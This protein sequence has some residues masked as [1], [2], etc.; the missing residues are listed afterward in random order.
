MS[1]TRRLFLKAILAI[2]SSLAIFPFLYGCVKKEPKETSKDPFVLDPKLKWG[3]APCRYC[4]TGCGVMVGVENGKIAAVVGDKLNSVNKGLL[5]AKGY[6]LPAM[7]YGKDRLTTPLIRKNGTLMPASWD[8]ALDLI[9]TRFKD[10]LD[11]SGP[12][13]VAMYGSGQWTI[14]DGYIATKF[15]RAAI[16]SNNLE[17][18]ARLCMASAVTGFYTTFG[19]DE[20]MGCYDDFEKADAFILWGNNMAEMHPVLFSRILE[21][22]RKSPWVQIIDIATRKTETTKWADIYVE[23]KP[24]T[25][26]ALANC[27]ARYIIK[28]GSYDRKFIDD[29]VLFKKG[30]TDIGYGLEDKFSFKDEPQSITMEELENSL[31]KYTFEYTSKITGVKAG[32]LKQ[33]AKIYADKFTKLVSLWCMGVNQHTRGTWMNNLIYNLHLLTGKI[34]IPG[35]NP[36]SL[37]GQPSACGTVREVGTLAHKLPANLV[38]MKPAHREKAAK[39]WNILPEKIPAKPGYNTMEMFRAMDRGDIKLMWIQCTNPYVTLPNLKRYTDSAKRD[40]SFI[41]VSDIYPTPTT[42]IAD[43]VLPSAAWVERE[44]MFGNSER[45]TQQWFKMVDPP[46]EARPDNWQIM[47]VAKRLGYGNLFNYNTEKEI[48]E[49]YRKFTLGVGKD[50]APY[51]TYTETR[52]LRWPVVNGKETPYRYNGKFDPY[53]TK[54]KDIEF[55]AN[56]KND[57]KA[58]IWFRPYEPAP[59]EPDDKYPFWLATGRVLEHWHTGSMTRRVP[60]LYKAKPFAYVEMHPDDMRKLGVNNG[61]KVRITSRRGEIVLNVVSDEYKKPQK[62]SVFVPFFDEKKLINFLTL[63]AYCPISK[64]PDYKKCAVKLER[65]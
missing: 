8:E 21:R 37:T 49:E 43:V 19:A 45:R 16:G 22:K 53:V 41:I 39:I 46:G 33:L 17:A 51:D 3:K 57:K 15:M 11:K 1:I 61:D 32:L 65:I 58:V 6:F 52:G 29:H 34:S 10:T 27:I 18:N 26:L 5:C 4:G 14:T 59:E 56:K 31:E 24:N 47:E 28:S 25:D 23:F 40:D 12:E 42:E 48:F 30:K 36:F 54:G 50:L 55:Y 63:D 64:Q 38:V 35:S 13:S 2:S 9:S 62:G 7:L 60:Q 44:G 20:P